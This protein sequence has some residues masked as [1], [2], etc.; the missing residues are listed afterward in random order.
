MSIVKDDLTALNALDTLNSDKVAVLSQEFIKDVDL[1][2]TDTTAFSS[3]VMI[4]YK[5]NH[6][7]YEVESKEGGFVVFSEVY[8]PKGWKLV[9]GE[10]AI[11]ENVEVLTILPTNY[12]LRGALLPAGKYKISMYFDPESAKIGERLNLLFHILLLIS[13]VICLYS[14]V[15]SYRKIE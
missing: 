6:L 8:Y 2:K 9:K 7:V 11:D 12:F 10:K 3:I 13:I 15:K 5:P 4:S 14:I 1:T